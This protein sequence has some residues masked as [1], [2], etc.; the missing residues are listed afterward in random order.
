MT[1]LV[2][3]LHA[4][5]EEI[6]GLSLKAE[7]LGFGQM[8]ARAIV[9][10]LV[11]LAVVRAGKKR[12]LGSATAFDVVLVIILGSIAARAI[13]GGPPFFVSMVALAAL[14]ALHW[15]ISAVG[16]DWKAF[17]S[18]VKGH[19]TVLIRDGRVD[20]KA[21]RDAHM[22]Q[23]DLDEDLRSHGIDDVKAVAEAR[24]ERNGELSVIRKH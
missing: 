1:A 11:L 6:F 23:D 22:A 13:T 24:L 19:S 17:S 15:A 2:E 14:V 3:T 18:L 4:W 12:F 21:L 16:R 9:M 10:Y 8:T 20:R 5:L 7:Q